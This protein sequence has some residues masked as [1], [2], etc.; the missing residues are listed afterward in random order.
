MNLRFFKSSNSYSNLDSSY[1]SKA[2]PLTLAQPPNSTQNPTHILPK[3]SISDSPIS[4][5][6][7]FSRDFSKQH[8]QTA[9]PNL[10]SDP[11][12]Q[13]GDS[14]SSLDLSTP[15]LSTRDYNLHKI[16]DIEVAKLHG[17]SI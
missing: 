3:P 5:Q 13:T 2:S 11:Y 4:Y 15:E 6:V 8:F 17:V 9:D 16:A 1:N 12:P 10:V 7:P 14:A